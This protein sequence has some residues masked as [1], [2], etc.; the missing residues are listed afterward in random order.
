MTAPETAL[1][2]A[3]RDAMDGNLSMSKRRKLLKEYRGAV[4][5]SAAARFER[6]GDLG[7]G[8]ILRE[9]AEGES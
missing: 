8:E 3:L 2:M 6:V 7:T 4:L 1:W 5:I 9:M